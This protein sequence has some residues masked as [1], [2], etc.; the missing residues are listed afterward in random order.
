MPGI[1]LVTGGS[2][3]IGRA[4]AE[5]LAA[6]GRDVVITG[7][8]EAALRATACAIAKKTGRR[9]EWA[10]ADVRDPGE[11]RRAFERADA[12]AR[13]QGLRLDVVVANAGVGLF[14]R[15]AEMTP[16]EFREVLDTNLYGAF[17]TCREALHR[18]KEGGGDVVVIGSLAAIN[19]FPGGTA[20]N[21]S[22]FG[23]HGFVQALFQEVRHDGIR[24]SEILPGS[25]ASDFHR[26]REA[27][28]GWMVQP[29]EVA[30]A[31]A[32]VIA[33]PRNAHISRVEIRPSRPPK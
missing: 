2:R 25:V 12:L 10:A 21:A 17:L 5:R 27:D 14:K 15:L 30:A 19:A 23:L 9:A 7:R 31:V 32:A 26:E 13:E 16:E 22:K 3:G 8:R 33:L 18:L 24:V 11:T 4:I 29:E 1:A 6:D 20:Y 28:L